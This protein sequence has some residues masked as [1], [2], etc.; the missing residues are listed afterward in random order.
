MVYT[1]PEAVTHLSRPTNPVRRRLISFIGHNAL[2]L[3]HTTNRV[4]SRYV[5]RSLAKAVSLLQYTI[6][7][8]ASRQV[9]C[10]P[11]AH[12]NSSPMIHV[13]LWCALSLR[14][15]VKYANPNV[16][17]N[18]HSIFINIMYK[19]QKINQSR[20]LLSRKTSGVQML[21]AGTRMLR[22]PPYSLSFHVNL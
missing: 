17:S 14:K 1:C 15:S 19:A 8:I 13:W 4:V 12:S 10:L 18:R 5:Y 20:C 7:G 2:P 3:R 21:V 11:P 16:N 22:T 6:T 9:E